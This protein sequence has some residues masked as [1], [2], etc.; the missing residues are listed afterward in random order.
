M[1]E[2][3]M[4]KYEL[5]IVPRFQV[6]LDESKQRLNL[7]NQFIKE[8][9]RVGIDFGKIPGTGGR[10][11]LFKPGAEKLEKIFGFYHEFY[12]LSKVEDFDKPFI[13]YQYKCVLK[14]KKTGI[15]E[16]ESIGSCNSKEKAKITQDPFTIMNTIDKIAQKRAFVGAVLNATALSNQFREEED[17]EANEVKTALVCC[18][19]GQDIDKTVADFSARKYGKMMCRECQNKKGN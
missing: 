10:P 17:N 13:M 18:S 19:C 3:Q 12:P 5:D 15:K 14:N 8:Q 6:T 2:E 16:G 7:M 4:Q 9:M 11:T 1:R